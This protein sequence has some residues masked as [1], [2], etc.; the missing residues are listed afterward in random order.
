MSFSMIRILI[1]AMAAVF[2]AAC[3]SDTKDLG[4]AGS[5]ATDD[6]GIMGDAMAMSGPDSGPSTDSG[7]MADS[8][9]DAGPELI[10]P[11]Q[12]PYRTLRS[13]GPSANRI[14]SISSSLAMVMSL[15]SWQRPTTTTSIVWR[16]RCS[17]DVAVA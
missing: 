3:S 11:A 13:S 16:P 17:N 2:L 1:I 10:D 6:S 12:E 15:K 7:A 5:A 8:G 4:D 9:H 14:E